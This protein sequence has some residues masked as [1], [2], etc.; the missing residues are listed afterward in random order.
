LGYD[1]SMLDELSR[2]DR[3]LLLKFVCAFAWT[4]LEVKA[5]EKR[6]V[7]RLIAR[8]ELDH[9]DRAQVEQWLHVGPAPSE[10]DPALVP[11]AHRRTFLEAARA[12]IYADGEVDDEEREQLERLK[13]ALGA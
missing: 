7:R 6:F 8:F 10:V 12:V 13:I 2:E 4:D 5:S 11:A 9:E 1:A 3:L